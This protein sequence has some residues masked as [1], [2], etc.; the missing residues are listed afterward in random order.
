MGGCELPLCSPGLPSFPLFG[1]SGSDR[2]RAERVVGKMRCAGGLVVIGSVCGR[3]L[4]YRGERAERPGGA[5]SGREGK[6]RTQSRRR[7]G[8]RRGALAPTG[9]PGENPVWPLRGREGKGRTQSR[10]REG[11]RRGALAPTGHP[12]E[13]PAWLL[14]REAQNK[15]VWALAGAFS[16]GQ[17]G[18]GSVP[19][20]SARRS[21]KM[22]ARR[23]A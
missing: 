2:S 10:G 13:N 20:F 19:S 3:P 4:P 6:G 21:W 16:A 22:R 7:E 17:A 8:F 1:P 15:L 5:W 14:S 12:G 18:M 11:F 23:G 9:P